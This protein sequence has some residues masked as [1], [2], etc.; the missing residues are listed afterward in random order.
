LKIDIVL[1]S[2]W[3]SERKH[4]VYEASHLTWYNSRHLTTVRR[5]VTA[6]NVSA[7]AFG[8]GGSSGGSSFARIAFKGASRGDCG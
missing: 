1:S 7:A 5:A 2:R 3:L 4:S 6:R 8:G